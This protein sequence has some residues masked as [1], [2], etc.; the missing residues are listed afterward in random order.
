METLGWTTGW[1]RWVG[2]LDG[3]VGLD[4]WMGTLGWANPKLEYII[5]IS[6]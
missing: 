4:N 1:E 2:Q 5:I 6:L 3:N